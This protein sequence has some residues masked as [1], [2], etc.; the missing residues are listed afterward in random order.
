LHAE[1][2]AYLV[3]NAVIISETSALVQFSLKSIPT[4]C[5]EEPKNIAII[6]V[7]MSI[8]LI[9]CASAPEAY[10][11][12]SY[13]QSEFTESDITLSEGG[14][15]NDQVKNIL[16]TVF[17]PETHV[18]IAVIFLTDYY[19][20]SRNLNGISY[21]IMNEGKSLHENIEKFV[22]VPRILIPAKI[23]FEKIQEL[24]IRSLG[25]YTLENNAKNYKYNRL[26][27]C[28]RPS[29]QAL[30]TFHHRQ[31]PAQRTIPFSIVIWQ[32]ITVNGAARRPST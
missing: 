7:T 3:L 31:H 27:Q 26:P 5:D 17:P 16:L 1:T 6:S 15:N 20:Y 2:S 30:I 28:P 9:G 19:S 24:G 11:S 13:R 22:P 23:S 32:V 8:L 4:H 18:S 14:L 29:S 12:F 25:E 21:Y 10:D